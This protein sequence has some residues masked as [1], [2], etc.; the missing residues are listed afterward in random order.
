MTME[1]L[2]KKYGEVPTT[3]DG[4]PYLVKR[5]KFG[6]FWAHPDYPKEKDII[7]MKKRPILAEESSEASAD[8]GE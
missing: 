5:G 7:R 8:S 3:K 6:E 1:G 4:R 2:K